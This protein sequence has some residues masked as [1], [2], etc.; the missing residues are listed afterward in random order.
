MGTMQATK[1]RIQ[2]LRQEFDALKK[3]KVSLLNMINESE[4]HE[5]VYNSNAIE[6]STLSLSE[7]EKILLE[8]HV[9]RNVSIREVFEAK[10]LA[11]VM[12]Y[13]E[14]KSKESEVTPELIL[15]LHKMLITGINDNIAGRFRQKNE[16]VKVGT[17]IAP[18]PEHLEQ[19]IDAAIERFHT[20]VDE[21]FLDKV[22]RFHLEFETIHPFND[23]NGRIGR[24]LINY[25]LLRFGFPTVIIPY[26]DRKTYY[27]SFSKYRSSTK[28]VD[29]MADIL[30]LSLCES[31]HKRIAY[32][33]GEQIIL[34]TDYAKKHG[35][36]AN[37]LLNKAKRQT[38]PAFREK[39]IW[40]IGSSYKE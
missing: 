19:M 30:F 24:V 27:E 9:S 17:H 8:L 7:T 10:N 38:I 31:L 14:K 15:F 5:H 22:A 39:G 29:G 4:L 6:N 12:D 32:L 33:K 36:P 23:G 35:T 26:K 13:I 21:Y 2:V 16:Y 37:G 40:K 1:K 3:A 11:R 28:S 20:D 25:Q 34:L 18:A